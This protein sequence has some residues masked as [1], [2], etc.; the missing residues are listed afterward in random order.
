MLVGT[1]PERIVEAVEKVL[2]DRSLYQRMALGG[3]PFGDG[4]ASNRIIEVLR[5]IRPGR[6]E[7]SDWLT[8]APSRF[9]QVRRAEPAASQ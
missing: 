6:T 1:A 8:M 4:K 5:H 3:N 2:R 9:G 7:K